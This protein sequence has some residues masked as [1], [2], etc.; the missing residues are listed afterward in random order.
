MFIFI[1][2]YIETKKGFVANRLCSEMTR[3]LTDDINIKA[4]ISFK[5]A[6]HYPYFVCFV[7]AAQAKVPSRMETTPID[8]ELLQTLAFNLHSS[9]RTLGKALKVNPQRINVINN[10]YNN[11]Y[12]KGMA[13]FEEWK[14]TPGDNVTKENLQKAL[15]EA[16]IDLSCCKEVARKYPYLLYKHQ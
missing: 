5:G 6:A 7:L 13:M 9:W 3:H 14:K 10:N 11:Y 4:L 1:S 2:R 15:E 12:E 8:D 16:E